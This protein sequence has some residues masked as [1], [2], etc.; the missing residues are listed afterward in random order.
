MKILPLA[1]I[2]ILLSVT[3]TGQNLLGF[4]PDEITEYIKE[5]HRN[6]V[7]DNNSRNEYYDYLKYTDG[8]SGTT[9][10]YFFMS[11]DKKCKRV[12]RMHVHSLKDEVI[13]EM[14][15]LYV[16]KGDNTWVDEKKENRALIRLVNEEWFF[17]INIEPG[18]KK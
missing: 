8:T 3:L 13:R 16:K 5:N 18:S 6:L 4:T 11:E 9:T 7:K 1:I 12:K 14:D 15:S 2:M 10:V 17:T